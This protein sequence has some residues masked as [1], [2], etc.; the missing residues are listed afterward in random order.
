MFFFLSVILLPFNELCRSISINDIPGN[1]DYWG[2][3][4]INYNGALTSFFPRSYCKSLFTVNKR[5]LISVPKISTVMNIK[6]GSKTFTATLDDNETAK[7]FKAM[8]PLTI[9]MDDLNSNEKK[10]DLLNNLPGKSVNPGTIHTGD[11]MIW[12]G[13][14]LVLFYKTFSTPY[15][16]A[17]LGHID[18]PSGLAAILGAGSITVIY[19]LTEQ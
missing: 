18:D 5:H 15:T 10:H 12:S 17:K 19:E 1:S 8:L 14:T 7:A 6:I 16:Y 3:A 2:N 11:L 13:N 4:V 9:K